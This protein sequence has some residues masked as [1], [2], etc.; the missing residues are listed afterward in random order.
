MFKDAFIRSVDEIKVF[1]P[2]VDV[3][4]ILVTWNR[5]RTKQLYIMGYGF[6]GHCN[7]MIKVDQRGCNICGRQFRR[8][9]RNSKWRE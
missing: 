5:N 4:D 3:R 8:R 1:Y 9:T 7:Y 2:D 6:C